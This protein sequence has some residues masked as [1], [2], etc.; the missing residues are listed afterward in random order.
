METQK[1]DFEIRVTA[2]TAFT[3]QRTM[4]IDNWIEAML[5]KADWAINQWA[6]RIQETNDAELAI[7]GGKY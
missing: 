7:L 1:L 5:V 2:R 4:L 6:K 3:Y